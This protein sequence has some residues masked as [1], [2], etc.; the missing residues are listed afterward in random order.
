MRRLLKGVL[1]RVVRAGEA[2]AVVRSPTAPAP[3]ADRYPPPAVDFR[4]FGAGTVLRPPILVV[5]AGRMHLGAG[6]VVGEGSVL[7]AGDGA[8]LTIGD[9]CRLG[10]FVTVDAEVHVT[11]EAG[12]VAGELVG[13]TDHWGPDHLG[14]PAPAAANVTIGRGARL[15]DGCVIGPGVTIGERARVLPGAVVLADVA[16]GAT[17]GGNPAV[18]AGPWP[19]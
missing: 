7:R 11:L 3:R 18:S 8:G 9:R 17:A 14:C 16:A 10:R 2:L 13:V 5:G 1:R 15:G 19:T 4:L 6:V 12:V